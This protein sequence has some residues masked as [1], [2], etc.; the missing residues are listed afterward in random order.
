MEGDLA[1]FKQCQDLMETVQ[2]FRQLQKKFEIIASKCKS[3]IASQEI[4]LLKRFK[5]LIETGEKEFNAE[6]K[7]LRE[8]V[9]VS[10]SN[11]ES[12]E[13]QR[14]DLKHNLSSY[15]KT[16]ENKERELTE[17][18]ELISKIDQPAEGS[19]DA[20]KL[21]STFRTYK[22]EYI[23]LFEHCTKNIDTIL[24]LNTKFNNTINNLNEKVSKLDNELEVKLKSKFSNSNLNQNDPVF[25]TVNSLD[26]D[27]EEVNTIFKEI[28]AI[29]YITSIKESLTLSCQKADIIKS[30]AQ[31]LETKL[32][33]FV[34]ET[35]KFTETYNQLQTHI[36]KSKAELER[37]KQ[38]EKFDDRKRLA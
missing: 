29:S 31:K 6:I 12:L 2:S 34:Q 36:S 9:Q 5:D 15:L 11:A 16:L 25:E 10:Y 27:I 38:S 17:L 22:N 4:V 26:N 7:K 13:N 19:F 30:N 23:I 18:Y 14:K 8:G 28:S 1:I 33:T 24:S 20:E 21:I 35:G 37:A 32:V 3:L